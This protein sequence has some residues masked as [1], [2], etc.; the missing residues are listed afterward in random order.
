MNLQQ[1]LA[2]EHQGLRQQA[3]ALQALRASGG[4]EHADRLERLQTAIRKHFDKEESY[5]RLVDQGKRYDDRGTIHQLRND[6][7]ALLFGFESL[8]LRLKKN[9]PQEAWWTQVDELL[10]VLLSHLDAEERDFF[11][12]A[13]RLL[14][15]DERQ[16]LEK[17][18]AG[19]DA[20]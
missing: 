11:P 17:A 12:R 7:A 19:M 14:K 20:S 8:R 10:R 15:P 16:E 13:D 6:H 2:G 3:Q 9:G 18:W 1:L 4:S 5:Y